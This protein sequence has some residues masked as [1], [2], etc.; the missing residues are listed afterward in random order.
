MLLFHA[1]AK[2]LS[3][4]GGRVCDRKESC[5]ELLQLFLLFAFEPF[6]FSPSSHSIYH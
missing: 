2:L 6:L 1:V 4:E 5:F 3:S